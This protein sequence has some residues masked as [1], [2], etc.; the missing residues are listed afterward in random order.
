M[1]H[2]STSPGG[3]PID[4]SRERYERLELVRRLRAHAL[5]T[6][7]EL[8]RAT[9]ECDRTGDP[10]GDIL[11]SHGSISED[12]RVATL[13]ERHQLRRVVLTD[14]EP[15]PA[16]VRRL[17]RGLTRR[18]QALP[19][20]ETD[21][22][23]LLAVA[24]PL[25]DEDL[26]AVAAALGAPFDQLLA[27]R[28]ELDELIQRLHLDHDLL[29][30]PGAGS[31]P[32]APSHLASDGGLTAEQQG[33][34]MLLVVALVGVAI[35]WPSTTLV[36]LLVACSVYAV[37]VAAYRFRLALRGLGAEP[38][39]QVSPAALA[40]LDER[41]L[42]VYTVLVPLHREQHAVATLVQDLGQLDYPRTRLDVK[43]LCA[44]DDL[45]TIEAVRA[46]DLPPHYHLVVLPDVGP[47]TRAR[48]RSY[49]LGL[50]RGSFC[51]TYDTG[52]RPDPDQLK[53]ALVAFSAAADEVVGLQA[54]LQPL[55][56]RPDLLTTW[57]V[58]E[59]A[60]RSEL[61]LP[62]L[63]RAGAPLPLGATS[64]HFRTRALREVGAWDPVNLSEDVDL[65]IR[66]HRDGL[67]TAVID[68]TTYEAAPTDLD[69]WMREQTRTTTGSLQ[70][71]LVHGR[72]PRA[73]VRACGAD[74]FVSVH[75][76]L[77]SVLVLLL[78][79]LLWAATLAALVAPW[80]LPVAPVPGSVLQ[81]P[82]TALLV[83]N[84]VFVYLNIV[85]TLR[86]GDVGLT[87]AT[88]LSPL[89]WALMSVAAWRSAA[90]L[91]VG[92]PTGDLAW[93]GRG[94]G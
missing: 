47:A 46:L 63:D 92:R 42:P 54:R 60:V 89:H 43:L 56:E 62:A 50:A 83:G 28:R 41:R 21:G 81:A 86:R 8:D 2:E 85:A 16:V 5:A 3:A 94:E 67:R 68:S 12:L 64:A 72:H 18:L 51:V 33:V 76:T 82:V 79:P 74:G 80:I 7:D 31:P 6:E 15:D 57:K 66:L 75:L 53:K 9:S 58:A 14:F 78:N 17:P 1:I 40:S 45:A 25:A 88:L 65:G 24:H 36:S 52:S 35:L 29:D 59:Q 44:P 30:G 10:L 71:W 39:I 48:A 32:G 19:V 26:D 38:G 23:V 22:T 4:S 69:A 61:V 13:S 37:L 73:L 49:G 20:A 87:R 27:H 11:V 84:V 93:A 34:L 90:R 91:V 70:T 77:G 55:A